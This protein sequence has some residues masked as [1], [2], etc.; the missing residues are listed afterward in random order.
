M[1]SLS[2]D[3]TTLLVSAAC[4]LRLVVACFDLR[5]LFQ[6]GIFALVFQGMER[7]MMTAAI[8]IEARSGL[9]ICQCY[10]DMSVLED[11]P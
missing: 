1:G 8:A 2:S 4:G 3:T 11:W 10:T 6:Y 5:P 7:G 9:H